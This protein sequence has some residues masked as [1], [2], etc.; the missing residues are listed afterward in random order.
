MRILS[1]EGLKFFL[2]GLAINHVL[3]GF[4]NMCSCGVETYA[5]L[6]CDVP[7]ITK[8]FSYF[9]FMA[10]YFDIIQF[11][12]YRIIVTSVSLAFEIWI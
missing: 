2:S 5:C 12:S 3:P 9:K 11:C 1:V 6:V 8:G 10:I 4:S 7:K